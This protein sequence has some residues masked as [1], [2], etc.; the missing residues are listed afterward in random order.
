M[1]VLAAKCAGKP[2]CRSD[3]MRL[4][5]A[6]LEPSRAEAGCRS[7]NFYSAS[8]HDN[9]FLFFEE[10]ADQAALDFHFATPHFQ[11]FIAEFSGL[12]AGPPGIRVYEIGE[13]R[14]LEM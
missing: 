12:L 11:K 6:M 10:W 2:E 5:S 13:T 4:A 14:D 8:E 3:I 7:Y 1:I 9:E